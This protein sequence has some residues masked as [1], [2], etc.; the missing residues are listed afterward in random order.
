MEEKPLMMMTSSELLE[1][2]DRIIARLPR[3]VVET[4]SAAP[5]DSDKVLPD[6]V[7]GWTGLANLFGI[8]PNTA[9]ARYATGA[10]KDACRM[11]QGKLITQPE[12]AVKAWAEYQEKR[13]DK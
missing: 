4:A 3:K 12:R 11:V 5:P 2:A 13:K 10:L 6:Y 1:L 8:T 7:V 9:K